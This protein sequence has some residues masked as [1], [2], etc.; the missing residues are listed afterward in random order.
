MNDEDDPVLP[1]AMMA[2]FSVAIER[3]SKEEK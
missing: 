3:Q 1:L 2:T